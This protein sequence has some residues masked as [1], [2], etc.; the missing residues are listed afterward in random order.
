MQQTWTGSGNVPF[1][2]VSAPLSGLRCRSP[3]LRQTALTVTGFDQPTTTTSIAVYRD[4]RDGWCA[5]IIHVHS[6][7]RNNPGCL[8]SFHTPLTDHPTP[9]EQ[10]SPSERLQ[11]CLQTQ[12]PTETLEPAVLVIANFISLLAAFIGE[13]LTAQV[14]QGAWP[15]TSAFAPVERMR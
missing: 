10:R 15:E 6:R 9:S 11:D 12:Q 4:T 8:D 5:T 7:C 1:L 3:V 2:A 14:V 13:R